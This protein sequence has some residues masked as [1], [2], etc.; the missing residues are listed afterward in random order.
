D[1]IHYVEVLILKHKPRA[2][3][4]YEGDNDAAYGK[5]PQRIFNDF[6]YLAQLCREQLPELR[7]Y[8]IEAKPSIARWAIAEKMQAANTM[9]ADFCRANEGF[10]YIDVWPF[11]LGDKGEPRLELLI[12]DKL[13]LNEAGYDAWARAIAPILIQGEA[14]FE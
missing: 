9:I 13:H 3:L 8:I 6:K 1:V 2:V 14:R 4:L 5:S 10:T 11:L 7:F 12:A